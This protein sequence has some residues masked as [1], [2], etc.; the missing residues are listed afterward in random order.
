MSTGNRQQLLR[1]AQ[2]QQISAELK[3]ID[4]PFTY[5]T[6]AQNHDGI[7]PGQEYNLY[8]QYLVNWY[9]DKSKI[10]I[11]VNLQI[12]LNYLNLLRQ[13]QLFFTSEEVEKWYS[14]I[15]VSNEKELLLSIPF[16]AKKLKDIALYYISLRDNVKQSKIKNNLIG[17]GTGITLQLRDTLLKNYTRKPNTSISIPAKI[18]RDVP[19]LSAVQDTINIQIEELYDTFE[20]ADHSPTMPVSAYY[21][22]DTPEMEDY[23][24]SLGLALTS[25]DWIYKTGVFEISGDQIV[26][27]INLSEEVLNKYLS[28]DK[29]TSLNYSVCAVKDFYTVSIGQSSNFFFWP[30]GAYQGNIRDLP[31]YATI[32]LSAT[33]IETLATGGSSIEIADTIFV[34]TAR[35][36]QGA[37]LRHEENIESHPTM[38]AEFKSNSTTRFK[39]PWPGF[40][41][42]AEDV[43]WTG[44]SFET[45]PRFFYLQD[46][47]KK[48]IEAEYWS[49]STSLTSHKPVSLN[50]TTVIDNKAFASTDFNAADRISIWEEPPLYTDSSYN[51]PV[52]EGWLYK[53]YRT[54]ISIAP[55]GDSTIV[56]PYQQIDPTLD[57]PTNIP[58]SID[59][60]CLPTTLSAIFLPHS[61]A[62]NNITSADVIYK[63]QNYKDTSE[64]AVEGAWLSGKDVYYSDTKIDT[65]LQNSFN[66]LFNAGTYTRFVWNDSTNPNINSIFRSFT[67]QSDCKLVN[68]PGATYKDHELCTCRQVLFTPFG[69]PGVSFTDNASYCDYIV[70]DDNTTNFDLE[71]WVDSTGKTRA[72]SDAFAWFK[73]NNSIGWGDGSWTTGA[74]NKGFRLE[75]GKSYIYYRQNIRAEDPTDKP[76]PNYAIRAINNSNSSN[77]KW[78][79]ALKDKNNNWYSTDEESNMVI[80]PGNHI[81]YSRQPTTTFTVSKSSLETQI[82][83]ENR[84]SIWSNNDYISIGPS[85]TGGQQYFTV[86]YPTATYTSTTEGSQYPEVGITNLLSVS[87]WHVETPAGT[88]T[89]YYN[90]PS[91][92]LTPTTTGIYSLSVVAVSATKLGLS[93]YT[94]STSG[95]YFFNDI[96]SVTAISA[97]TVMFS[98]TSIETNIPGFVINTPLYGWD[99]NR[100]VYTGRTAVGDFGA[101]PF[102]AKSFTDKSSYTDYKGVL[103][104][105]NTLRLTDDYNIIT[106]PIISNITLQ[107]GSYLEYQRKGSPAIIWEQPLHQYINVDR[108]VWST[109]NFSTTGT[110]NLNGIINNINRDLITQALSSSSSLVLDSIVDNEPVEIYYN[111]IN[112]FSW[113]ITATPIITE[114][115]SLSAGRT[116]LTQAERPWANLSNR[117]YPNISILPT[118]QNLSS[119]NSLGG[120]FVPTNLG[121][122]QYI[123]RDYTVSTLNS[124]TSLTGAFED[125]DKYIA[126]RGFTNQDQPTPYSITVENNSWIKEP[127]IA[128]SIAGTIKKDVFKK[129]QKFIPYQS[130][131]EGS[132]NSLVRGFSLPNSRQTPWTGKQDTEWNDPGNYPVS[133]TGELNV[134]KW[135]ES[136]VLK[137]TGL[138]LDNWVTDI[139]GNQY[140]L[141]KDIKNTRPE[142]RKNKYG[143]IWTRSNAQDI[144]SASISLTGVFDTYKNLSLYNEMTGSGVKHIDVFFDSL[145][146]QT[147]GVI[148]FER[149][150]YDYDTDNISSIADESRYLSLAIPVQAN[151]TR[152]LSGFTPSL[153]AIAT[154]GETW[155]LPEQKDVLQTICSL[156]ST[157]LTP[158]I[159]IHNLNTL[160][161]KRVFPLVEEDISTIKSLSSL[162]LQSITTPTFSY[163]QLKKQYVMSIL[164]KDNIGSDIIIE[165][166]I[167]DYAELSLDGI[168]VYRPTTTTQQ[169]QEPPTVTQPLYI[170]Q[171]YLSP[172]QVQLTG[173]PGPVSFESL[174]IPGWAS[175]KAD[176]LLTGT[177]P[178]PGVYNLPFVVSNDVGPTYYTLTLNTV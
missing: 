116:Q 73:T 36:T 40:G 10:V 155:F 59:T 23:F 35:D 86:T 49:N 129:Y 33:G 58:E 34:K 69:H 102:W 45:E 140:G 106:Q 71:S 123:N 31:R 29:Y 172:L 37:W 133:F 109:I 112:T 72:T 15:D 120:Y 99:Y 82:V 25:T 108:N 137:Q 39:Y 50:S 150:A 18:W 61:T 171:S 9:K 85:Q 170:E 44:P 125:P 178:A 160:I 107:S 66:G 68:T 174:G 2:P 16:F 152:E 42:S 47:L 3:D 149:L 51:G 11:D 54:D 148:I 63:I 5:R 161:L 104:W 175:L 130:A 67:H 114:S 17:T 144:K 113:P 41:L 168:V 157:Y 167:N 32:P 24:S 93:T 101:R 94:D 135:A 43:P 154:V 124:S 134:D 13:L 173:T 26:D 60:S 126:G 143:Q 122:S 79:R 22:V 65:T 76:L 127:A 91:L 88:I 138:Q 159:Y 74:G 142:E 55:A 89:T 118:V 111:A 117:Y 110:T 98:P 77:V 146:V 70:E 38:K 56:W 121:A 162:N 132:V 176:G 128:G 87:A 1:Y 62:S 64:N 84:G 21:D 145:Y 169:N 90:T 81:L 177:V 4:S 57:Y 78:I 151:L 53:M 7:V 12:K 20:Y 139:F 131:Y 165:L 119:V 80:Y 6:W 95:I 28:D 164:G 48:A 19:A 163:S 158:E 14:G 30:Y 105:G 83:N 92:L 8:N 166:T 75:A 46:N 115:V 141:Y 27:S 153:C 103:S 147:S 96:P 136:Q 100:S 52:K 97:T 156:S